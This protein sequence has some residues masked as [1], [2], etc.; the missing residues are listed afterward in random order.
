VLIGSDASRARASAREQS[1]FTTTI[2]DPLQTTMD[3]NELEHI[4]SLLDADADLREVNQESHHISHPN[5]SSLT[6]EN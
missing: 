5:S 6:A 1:W 4:N 2:W 3:P